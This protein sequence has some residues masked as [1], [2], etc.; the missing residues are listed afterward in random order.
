MAVAIFSNPRHMDMNRAGMGD[1]TASGA[2]SLRI[3]IVSAYAPPHLG[4][5]E[6]VVAQQATSLAALGHQVTVLTSQCAAGASS[7]DRRTQPPPYADQGGYRMIRVPA[8]NGFEHRWGIAVPVYRPL[9]LLRQQI[10]LSRDAD[11]IHVYD[12]YHPSSVLA[13]CLARLLRKPLFATQSVGIVDHD[14]LMVRLAQRAV[15]TTIGRLVWR[16]ASA[17]TAFTPIVQD[18]LLERHVPGAKIRLKYNGIDTREFH[19]GDAESAQATRKRHGLPAGIPVVFYAGRLVP[20]KGCGKLLAASGPEYQVVLAGPG[21]IPSHVPP[22]VTFL[23]PVDRDDLLDLY[24]ASDIFAFPATGEILTLVM[25]EA[26]ACGLPVVATADPGYASYDLDPSGIAL[27]EPEPAK[28]RAE[29]LDILGNPER[30]QRMQVYSRQLAEE[31]LDW[32]RNAET[33]RRN[34]PPPAGPGR[35]AA[36]GGPR[37]GPA[38]WMVLAGTGRS[39]WAG[40]GN[41]ACW[42][43]QADTS[44]R[45]HC[46]ASRPVTPC[47]SSIVPR[48]FRLGLP[49]GQPVHVGFTVSNREGKTMQY[50]Y[51]I[52]KLPGGQRRRPAPPAGRIGEVGTRRIQLVSLRDRAPALRQCALPHPGLAARASGDHRLPAHPG[53]VRR[54]ACPLSRSW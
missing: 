1:F 26:M 40:L 27:V 28:L 38:R 41:R 9:R 47:S 31:R 3:L 13:S 39:G 45:C 23:G 42:S 18:F 14:M 8:W 51:V 10:R 25:Q 54:I 49:P 37:P 17:V 22:H 4:G 19:P 15:Y 53:C 20:K 52:S 44:G 11:V 21:R 24:Q 29:F 36:R 43:R 6:V 33:S 7:P 12:V 48:F 34:T 16:W 32:Q 5:V 30:R 50:R 46:Y 35:A 2:A